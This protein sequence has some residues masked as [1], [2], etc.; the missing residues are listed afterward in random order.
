MYCAQCGKEIRDT[1]KF[2]P[3]CGQTTGTAAPPPAA[4]QD[5]A[6][7]DGA[8]QDEATVHL[9]SEQSFGPPPTPP[10]PEP[11][12]TV[13]LPP[14]QAGQPYHSQPPQPP[15]RLPSRILHAAT[16]LR[17][18]FRHL[19][20]PCLYAATGPGP[21]QTEMAALFGPGTSLDEYPGRRSVR[22]VLSDRAI[23]VY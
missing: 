7:Q 1:A 20:A 8:F 10:P 4:P 2:C 9:P 18:T 15:H 13:Y 12:A 14:E 6:L 23:L 22:A 19:P 3:F 11:E 5:D 16:A 21:A 17:T